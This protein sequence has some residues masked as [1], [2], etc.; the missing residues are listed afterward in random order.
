MDCERARALMQAYLDDELDV[1][2]AAEMSSHLL[3]CTRCGAAFEELLALRTAIERH[4]TRHRAPAQLQQ[5]IRASL[6]D[7][8]PKRWVL[9]SWPLAR[10]NLALAA[11]SGAAFAVTLAL[12]LAQ[13]SSADRLN[14]EIV[15]SHFRSLMADHLA[16]V[17]SSDQHTVKPWFGGKLD[18]SPPV[19]DFGQRGFELVGGRLDYVAGRPVAA[20]AYRHRKHVLNLYVWPATGAPESGLRATSQ[21]GFRLLDWTQRDM[22]FVA[23]SDMNAQDLTEFARTLQAQVGHGEGSGWNQPPPSR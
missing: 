21:R 19:Y 6:R 13:P 4:G 11:A 2:A 8:K 22:H 3:A 7:A 20:L 17:A 23:I 15:A 5:R 16:D 1:A 14:E 10:I 9:P 12:L 18:F